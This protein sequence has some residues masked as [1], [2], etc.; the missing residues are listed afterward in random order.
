MTTPGTAPRLGPSRTEVLEA[1]RAVDGPLTAL[2]V[3]TRVGV[4]ANSARFHLEALV[5]AGIVERRT[6]E[7]SARGR[8]RVFY[9]LAPAALPTPEATWRE[10]AGMLA[11]SLADPAPTPG[12]AARSAGSARGRQ[13]AGRRDS[14]P[15]GV[16]G[17]MQTVVETMAGL[18]FV[19]TAHPDELGR[20]EIA[21][22][23]FLELARSHAQVICPL[24]RGLM[25]GVLA[26]LDAPVTVDRLVPFEQPD[27]CV[28]HLRP[29]RTHERGPHRGS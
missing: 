3:A 18:G 22:C 19:S 26:E 4:H 23:P 27:L 1:L 8:P 13:L 20:I 29:V 9:A 12:A 10:L 14:G 21:P 15:T 7:R 2:D 11:A 25:E 17:A 28:A 5:D 16:P 6:E 24:H